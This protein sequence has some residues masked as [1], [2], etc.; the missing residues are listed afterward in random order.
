VL[1][2]LLMAS[3]AMATV[4]ITITNAGGGWANINYNVTSELTLPRAFALNITIASTTGAKMTDVAFAKGTGGQVCATCQ[5]FV[6]YPGNILID[7]GTGTVTSWGTPV[8]PPGAPD[9]P[10]QLPGT[11]I[12]V[13]LGSLYDAANPGIPNPGT[14]PLASGLLMKVKV[15]K[16]CTMSATEE[17]A[18]RGG[19]VLED[20]LVDPTV[21]VT[22]ATGVSI[23]VDCLYVGRVFNNGLVVTQAMVDKWVSLNKPCCWCCQAQKYGNGVYAGGSAQ[24]VDTA[25]LGD[26]KLS[27]M[28][29]YTSLTYKRC[30][31][32]NLSGRVDTADL[33]TVKLH[34]MHTEGACSPPESGC[35]T[36]P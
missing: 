19:V 31:D 26:V 4:A 1:A 25:D 36:L 24:R 7:E 8:A 17:A 22:G 28:Q 18:V 9:A 29:S 2:A 15:D 27:W 6:I 33:G 35:V 13:E 5:P 20:P 11:S 21:D 12:V 3:P 34:W 16:N 30:S 14:R 10:G 23:P 32:Y